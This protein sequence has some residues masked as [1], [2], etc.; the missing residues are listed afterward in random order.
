MSDIEDMFKNLEIEFKRDHPISYWIDNT[1]FKKKS[2]FSYSPHHVLFHPWILIPDLFREI[3]WAYQRVRFGNDERI[4]WS[5]D[6]WL[7]PIMIKEL[8]TLKK[9]K[10]GVPSKF[11]K[12][13]EAT[14]NE[15]FDEAQRL[16]FI[17]LDKMIFGF[18]CAQ[19]LADLDYNWRN[20]D[21]EKEL[22][23]NFDIGMNSFKEHYFSLWD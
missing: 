1:L 4:S 10:Q 23:D 18:E 14:E 17:E 22:L 13:Q 6:L 2:L 19:K 3:R 12:S 20:T 21:V 16:W 5:I 7:N 9:N 8:N 15:D 11:F